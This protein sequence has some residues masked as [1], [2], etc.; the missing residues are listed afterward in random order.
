[1]YQDKGKKNLIQGGIVVL[2]IAITPFL[3]YLYKEFPSD[4]KIWELSFLSIKT[5]YYFSVYDLVWYVTNKSVPI[6]LL[7]IWFFTCKHWWHWIILVPL[8]MYIFQLW[9]IINESRGMDEVELIYI[10]PLMMILIPS[11]YVIRAK[12]FAKIRDND[13]TTFEEELSQKRST[14]QQIKDLFR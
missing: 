5:D 8:S 7:S 6:L 3:F 13:L 4:S 10:L 14:W 1:M 9:G 2:I 12:L 11:V